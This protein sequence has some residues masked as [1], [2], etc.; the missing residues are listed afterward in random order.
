MTNVLTQQLGFE[1]RTER[2]WVS[3]T[4]RQISRRFVL[5]N[6]TSLTASL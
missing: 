1:A 4:F 5:Q 3:F 6:R 2:L